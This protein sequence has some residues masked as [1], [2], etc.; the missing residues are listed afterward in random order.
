MNEYIKRERLFKVQ[1]CGKMHWRLIL[2]HSILSVYYE[3]EDES[4]IMEI[5]KSRDNQSSTNR[6]YTNKESIWNSNTT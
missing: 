6:V 3:N 2:E 1:T 4:C 5:S